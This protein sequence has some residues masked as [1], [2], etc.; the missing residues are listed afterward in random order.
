MN[1]HT[2]T[3]IQTQNERIPSLDIVRILYQTN[4]IKPF[5]SITPPALDV[6]RPLSVGPS[7]RSSL[8]QQRHYRHLSEDGRALQTRWVDA[9]C[10]NVLSFVTKCFRVSVKYTDLSYE[11][12][13]GSKTVFLISYY[14]IPRFDLAPKE[15]V[16]QRSGSEV[17][18]R[19]A[20]S[21]YQ[22][23]LQPLSLR[24][25][26]LGRALG[27]GCTNTENWVWLLK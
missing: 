20:A 22:P 23:L 14:S 27:N 12:F 5:L 11:L 8:R 9:N 21:P 3:H 17:A 16:R 18:Y 19:R 10:T 1:I 4:T 26:A 7:P 15:C 2:Y 13:I 24:A 6:A 25:S